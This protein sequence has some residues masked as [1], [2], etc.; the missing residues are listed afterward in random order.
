[1]NELS[2]SSFIATFKEL[3]IEG[4]KDFQEIILQNI[5]SSNFLRYTKINNLEDLI[6][7]PFLK[8]L[9]FQKERY[10]MHSLA[11]IK[12]VHEINRLFQDKGLTPIYLKGIALQNE[13]DDIALRPLTDIDIL[14]KGSE[15][16]VAYE[17]LHR[18]NLL[19]SSETKYLHKENINQ[20]CVNFHHIQLTTKNNI[21]IELHHRVTLS[22]DFDLCPIGMSFFKDYRTID[23]YGESLNIPSIENVII[24]QLIHFSLQSDF[25]KLLRTIN[26]IKMINN[27][28]QI[29]WH[30]LILKLN[31]IK[32]RKSICLSLDILSQNNIEIKDLDLIKP[33]FKDCFPKKE[34][35]T[36]AQNRLFRTENK[37]HDDFFYSEIYVP[38]RFLSHLLRVFMPEKIIL[39][40]KYKISDPSFLNLLKAYLTNILSNIYRL[41]RLPFFMKRKIFYPDNIKYSNSVSFWLNKN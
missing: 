30:E 24:H 27:N 33:H 40:Y 28:Y 12:E 22:R 15:L 10:Q 21:S 9:I 13:Y 5:L 26:D 32:I 16:L 8:K 25:K 3:D 4:R 7:K 18:N 39:I 37:I 1:M 38:N 20:F 17:I 11:I 31:N 29:N 19:S 23:Y 36:E 34:I 41:R 6:D 2:K 35:L 14:F